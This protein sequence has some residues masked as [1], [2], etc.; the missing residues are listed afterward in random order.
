MVKKLLY[1]FLALIIVLVV[2]NPSLNAFR[3]HGHYEG[4]EREYNFLLF[5][6]YKQSVHPAHK[7]VQGTDYIIANEFVTTQYLGILENFFKI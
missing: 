1:V 3:E 6:I 2:I 5:S 7:S 4:I